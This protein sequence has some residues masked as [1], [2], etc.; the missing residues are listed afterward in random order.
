MIIMNGPQPTACF[1][2]G[3]HNS[4]VD[5]G[6]KGPRWEMEYIDLYCFES[7][8]ISHCRTR[9]GG[10]DRELAVLSFARL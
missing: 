1:A 4:L 5:I 3:M 10:M 7:V 9:Q 8:H 2:K 6:Q